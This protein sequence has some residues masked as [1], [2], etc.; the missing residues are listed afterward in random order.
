M[1]NVV[2]LSPLKFYDSLKKQERFKPYA[3]GNINPLLAKSGELPNFQFCLLNPGANFN[4]AF[5]FPVVGGN[6][7][8]VTSEIAHTSFVYND[9][10]ICQKAGIPK[11]VGEYY[12][13]LDFDKEYYYSEVI[14]F[15]E[16]LENC[17]Y[18]EYW[19]TSSDF[20]IGN[21]VG[22][23]TFTNR[24][25]FGVYLKTFIGKPEYTFEE[26][27]SKRLGYTF[28]ES[29]V[30]KKVYKFNVL[31]PEF[32]CD[33]L[34]IVRLCGSKQITADGEITPLLSFDMDVDWQTQG[35]LASVNCE[36]E[37]D[38]VIVNFGSTNIIK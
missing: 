18:L 24:F 6:A 12:L 16:N 15:T 31:L 32:I 14:C 11:L 38:N 7:I 36:F 27:S 19:N 25:R 26:T 10:F 29:Q 35:D 22:K 34:R 8:D 21:N 13:V 17:I 23:V 28:V 30:S 5:L 4:N 2:C 9:I 3:H 1:A 20:E 33:A 37:T